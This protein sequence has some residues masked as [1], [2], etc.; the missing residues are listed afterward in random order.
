MPTDR[1]LSAFTCSV[2]RSWWGSQPCVERVAVERDEVIEHVEQRVGRDSDECR[3]DRV[4]R[5]H[6]DD[7][8]V[9]DVAEIAPEPAP[10]AKKKR[11]R[12]KKAPKTGAKE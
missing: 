11:R 2:V 3:R 12:R 4:G 9:G 6:V 7:V 10:P 1:G 5:G 8:E